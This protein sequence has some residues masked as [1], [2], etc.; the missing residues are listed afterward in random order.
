MNITQIGLYFRQN[1]TKQAPG[2]DAT[3]F[4]GKVPLTLSLNYAPRWVLGISSV[5][6]TEIS[7]ATQADARLAD[8]SQVLLKIM[9]S[10]SGI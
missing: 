10:W 5:A 2:A 8:V 4:L 3:G 1:E 6:L 7:S 9:L